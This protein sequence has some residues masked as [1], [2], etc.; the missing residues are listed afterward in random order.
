[1]RTWRR[2][3]NKAT[4]DRIVT[5]AVGLVGALLTLVTALFASGTTGALCAGLVNL[6]VIPGCALA[7]WLPVAERLARVVTVVAASLTWSVLITSALAWMQVT[8][9]WVLLVGT[10]GVSG[11]G[12]ATFLAAELFRYWKRE[13]VRAVGNYSYEHPSAWK[14][15]DPHS[16]QSSVTVSRRWLTSNRIL[17]SG[18]LVASAS[19]ATAV[20]VARGHALSKYG[21]LPVLGIPFLVSIVLTLGVLIAALRNVRAAWPSALAA[22]A[23]LLTEI[24]GTPALLATTALGSA[25]YKHFGV[26]DYIVHGGTL[27]NPLDI[28]Q[29]WPGFFATAAGLVRLSGRNPM[30]Y[31][32]WAQLFFEA[33][34]A[35]VIF[36]IARRFSRGHTIVP[37]ITVLLFET[38]YWEGTFYYSPQTLAFTLSLMFQYFLL[39]LLETTRLRWLFA[40]RRWLLIPRLETNT[41]GNSDALVTMTRIGGLVALF[42][43][44][45]ITHQLTPFFV[46]VG[47]TCFWVLGVLRRPMLIITLAIIIIAFESLHLPAVDQNQVL[48]GFHLSNVTGTASLVPASPQAAL[49]GVLA[50]TISLA[51]WGIT[52]G[53]VLSY[54]RRFGAVAIIAILAFAPITFAMVSNYD[55][56]AIYR[57]FLFS[58]PWCALIIASRLAPL[59]RASNLGLAAVGGWALFAALGSAQSQ[60]YGI[61]SFSQIPASEISASTYFL[62]HAPP[63][64][65]LVTAAAQNFPGRLNSRY[66]L[67]NVTH[68]QNDPSLDGSK[69]LKGPGLSRIS[70]RSLAEYVDRL[71][72]GSG[73]LVIAPPMQY[74]VNYYGIYTPNSLSALVPRLEES[75]Y[76]QVWYRNEGTIIFKAWPGGRPTEKVTNRPAPH[77][78]GSAAQ[79]KQTNPR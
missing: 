30:Q 44:I 12:S 64:T 46:I 18:L 79:S 48:T 74:F 77:R 49:A 3:A 36:A 35:L 13:P 27:N 68:T 45:V 20:T 55:G 47:V 32:N 50:K 67:H 26:V 21:L 4:E 23:L 15:T 57:V 34:N 62:D 61:F 37:Y 63:N 24:D 51:F 1:M 16:R 73:Y 65:V 25:T 10:A 14:A 5:A 40:G 8:S 52:A 7:C 58:S 19:W 78:V 31:A 66:A 69:M 39:P 33:L 28:Y 75:R 2:T 76:W 22:L 70:P 56:E 41:E 38:A 53:C 59:L 71:A 17:L 42:G 60:I 72:G 9:L 6:C 11:I 54:G 29:Q 43:A